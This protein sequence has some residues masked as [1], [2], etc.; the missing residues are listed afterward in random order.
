MSMKAKRETEIV[1]DKVEVGVGQG[2]ERNG[3]Q[4]TNI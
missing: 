4:G 3:S 2:R 1:I